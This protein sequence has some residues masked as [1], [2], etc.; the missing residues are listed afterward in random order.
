MESSV[1][2][3]IIRYMIWYDMLWYD[4]WCDMI[5]YMVWYN[6]ICD[7][8]YMIYDMM[9]CDMTYD[10]IWY[11]MKNNIIHVTTIASHS[12]RDWPNVMM[13]V[14]NSKYTPC[15]LVSSSYLAWYIGIR[16]FGIYVLQMT[17]N[18]DVMVNPGNE[19]TINIFVY[20]GIPF[21]LAP[22]NPDPRGSPLCLWAL[23]AASIVVS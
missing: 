18:Q 4:I 19:Q 3:S 6:M 14:V 12:V 21:I 9:W 22:S 7:M 8:W 20:T 1:D 2:S 11:D 10:M 23:R 17:S 16:C 13:T 5:W 15:V